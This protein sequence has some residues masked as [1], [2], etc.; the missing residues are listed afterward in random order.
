VKLAVYGRKTAYTI[1][2]KTQMSVIIDSAA[3]A[4]TMRFMLINLGASF[5]QKYVQHSTT[6]DWADKQLAALL[7]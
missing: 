1:Y 7:K 5:A 6:S 4:E 2:G 3:I